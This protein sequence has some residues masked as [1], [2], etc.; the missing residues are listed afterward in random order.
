M[1]YSRHDDV[2]FNA[3]VET[4]VIVGSRMIVFDMKVIHKRANNLVF[5][6]GTLISNRQGQVETSLLIQLLL[7]ACNNP[8]NIK[9]FRTQ[10]Y[11]GSSP[12]IFFV[13]L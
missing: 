9:S 12:C 5:F 7:H 10:Q 13:L 6:R 11:S 4:N 3:T 1:F 2:G 8:R